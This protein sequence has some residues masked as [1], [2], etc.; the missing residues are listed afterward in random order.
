MKNNFVMNNWLRTAGT[1]NCCFSHPFYLLFACYIVM[2]TGLNKKIETNVYLIDILP[3]MTILIIL[4]GI[5]FLIF[6]RIQ[7][8]L[9]L[10]R[11][12]LIDWF[13]KINIW[14]AP[15]LFIFV[16]MLMPIEGNVFGFIFI[17]VIFITGVIIAPII[18]IKSLR[19]AKKLKNER[20]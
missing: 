6:A 8:K 11:Q 2:A 16:M 10:S 19:L 18:L 15:G 4:T 17:P 13:I 12:E 14:S 7:N 20:T 9:N 1:L 5:R 3:F